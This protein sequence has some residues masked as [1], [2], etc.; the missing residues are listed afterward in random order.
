MPAKAP[1]ESNFHHFVPKS[2]L[3]RFTVDGAGKQIWVFDKSDGRSFPGGLKRTGSGQGYNTLRLSDGSL[4]NF[5]D[6]FQNIDDEFAATG[7]TLATRR[8]VDALDPH[9]RRSHSHLRSR[10][11]LGTDP[12]AGD[13]RHSVLAHRSPPRIALCLPR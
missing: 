9:P 5:E 4:W 1:N 12:V 13:A 10:R 3:R 7:N 8:R 2:A 11:D 6:A